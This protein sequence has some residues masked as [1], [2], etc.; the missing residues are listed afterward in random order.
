M[1]ETNTNRKKGPFLVIIPA[2]GLRLRAS[3]VEDKPH[4]LKTLQNAVGGLIEPVPLYE[5]I[6][7]LPYL[8]A[9]AN[10]NALDEGLPLNMVATM[11]LKT[12]LFGDIVLT[13]YDKE[14]GDALPLSRED[15]EAIA[16]TLGGCFEAFVEWATTAPTPKAEK[17]IM[18]EC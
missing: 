2:E 15:L 4:A 11:F 13:H 18:K 8:D 1:N 9:F 10:E 3:V 5:D 17:G 7:G 16:D 14:S 12:P 6:A